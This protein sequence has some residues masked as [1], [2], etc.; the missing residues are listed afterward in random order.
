MKWQFKLKTSNNSNSQLNQLKFGVKKG[1]E[2]TLKALLNVFGDS[3]DEKKFPH[4]LLLTNTQ[5]WKLRKAFPNNSAANTNLSK[6]QLHK[7]GQSGGFLGRLLGLLLK[8]RLPLTGNLPKPISKNVLIPLGLTTAASATDEAINKKMFGSGRVAKIF[9]RARLSELALH[10][11]FLQY[12]NF[13]SRNE[14]YNENS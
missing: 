13:E 3:N 7:I 10:T 11:A 2:V 12:N 4:K 5:I 14:W 1:T 6:P 9:D 8:N